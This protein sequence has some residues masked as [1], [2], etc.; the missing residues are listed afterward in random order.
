MNEILIDLKNAVNSIPEFYY[1]MSTVNIINDNVD[2]DNDELKF[3]ERRFVA[4]LKSEYDKLINDGSTG[5]YEE[6]N[7][8]FEVIKRYIYTDN[9]DKS[10]EATYK[11]L[12]NKDDNKTFQI[13]TTIPD[14]FIHK[15]QDNREEA[16]QKLVVEVKT[17]S[18]LD[19]DDFFLDLFK[20]N[21][22]VEKYNFQNGVYLIANNKSKTVRQLAKSYLQQRLYLTPHN[23]DRIY[24]FIKPNFNSDIEIIKLIDLWQKNCQ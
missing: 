2:I 17:T 3:Y 15:Q 18:Q 22:Y 23:R 7:T 4:Q 13:I 14:F 12:S 11:K 6:V 19:K 21:V 8:D 24:L 1:T 10:I 20:L 16:F 5:N 9:P